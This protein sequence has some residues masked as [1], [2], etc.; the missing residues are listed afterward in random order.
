[1]INQVALAFPELALKQTPPEK[2]ISTM[3]ST[4]VDSTVSAASKIELDQSLLH[5][6]LDTFLPKVLQGALPWGRKT[7][8]EYKNAE[9][10]PPFK[11][12]PKQFKTGNSPYTTDRRV[13]SPS[14]EKFPKSVQQRSLGPLILT[15]SDVQLFEPLIRRTRSTMSFLDHTLS[16]LMANLDLPLATSELNTPESQKL[17]QLVTA[18]SMAL[19]SA[20]RDLAVLDGNFVLKRRD[21]A[22][23]QLHRSVSIPI[24]TSLRNS[25]FDHRY[26]IGEDAVIAG[27]AKSQE[28][29]TLD[30]NIKSLSVLSQ[31]KNTGQGPKAKTQEPQHTPAPSTP[32]SKRGNQSRNKGRKSPSTAKSPVKSRPSQGSSSSRGGRGG[33]RG[34]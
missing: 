21:Q 26:I 13:L 6:K 15:E 2:F 22:I 33:K 3:E 24:R 32:T 9:L 7:E 31:Q 5:Q 1:V 28:E 30:L 25:T 27:I 8:H 14:W 17:K 19:S 4:V 23:S 34:K 12:W 29:I 11:D 18:C 20:T 16:T 10:I